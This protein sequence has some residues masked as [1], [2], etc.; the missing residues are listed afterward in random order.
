M[1]RK[2]WFYIVFFMIL[3]GGFYVFLFATIDSSK[4]LLP[5]LNVVQ[6]F[7]FERQDGQ[8]ISE[9]DVAGKVY[10]AEFFFTT[11]D[12]ICP[13][14]NRNMKKVFE[15]FKNEDD[16][17][18]LSHT[19]DPKTDDAARLKT[20]A[21]SLGADIK[22]WWFLTG[23]KDSLY[24]TARES[25]I[26]DDPNNNAA[27][28][29]EQFLHTQFFALIDR[30]GRVRGIYDGLKKDEIEKLITDIKDLLKEERTGQPV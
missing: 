15:Q 9:K 18:I 21:D 7:S 19:V 14:M 10:A 25:Y 22:T 4:S 5:V 17:L 20:Y 6:P 2:T 11:C 27:D 13:K 23:S 8:Q 16:F 26:L 1:K 29:D 12:G 28:I 30:N 24:K 3:F